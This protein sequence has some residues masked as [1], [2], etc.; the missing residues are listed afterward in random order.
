MYIW[1][2]DNNR[3][4]KSNK[5]T[6]NV[7]L[8]TVGNFKNHYAITIYATSVASAWLSSLTK[9]SSPAS[10]TFDS[11]T[12]SKGTLSRDLLTAWCSTTFPWSSECVRKPLAP[13]NEIIVIVLSRLSHGA[14]MFFAEFHQLPF[15]HIIGKREGEGGGAGLYPGM[16]IKGKI[17]KS[18]FSVRVLRDVSRFLRNKRNNTR[19]HV[20]FRRQITPHYS[21]KVVRITVAP[22][23]KFTSHLL[24]M[25]FITRHA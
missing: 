14:R 1:K 22:F 6:L 13:K 5:L 2:S 20:Y 17:F 10:A 18:I 25:D 21:L 12:P 16:N 11:V 19:S 24:I 23:V 8:I 4:F 7:H 3:N 15:Y 9:L